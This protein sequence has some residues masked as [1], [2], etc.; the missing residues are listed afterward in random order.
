MLKPKVAI[1]SGKD[2][3]EMVEKS[4]DLIGGIEQIIHPG[5]VVLIKPNLTAVWPRVH[6]GVITDARVVRALIRLAYSARAGEVIIGEGSGG[7]DTEEAYEISGIK[8]VA[9][10]FGVRLVD[11]NKDET[12]EVTHPQWKVLKKIPI[13]KTVLESD[14]IINV[15]VMKTTHPP[16][17]VSLSLKNMMGVL[18]GKG[19]F[20]GRYFTPEY[21]ESHGFWEPTGGK[22][23]IHE[24]GNLSQAVIDLNVAVRTDLV[25][26][27]GIVGLEGGGPITGTPIKMGLIIAGNNPVAVDAVTTTIMGFNPEKIKYLRY[28][29]ERGLSP[30]KLEDIEIVGEPISK[31]KRNFKPFPPP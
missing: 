7:A 1:V 29:A 11:F 21:V 26:V 13:A 10:E 19:I 2:I 16:F 31:V 27:D 6:P 30:I 9:R 22:K 4:I 18:P 3:E 17:Y 25:V 14:V 28:A 15:P 8:G 12:I 20:K 24:S 23:L 5:D